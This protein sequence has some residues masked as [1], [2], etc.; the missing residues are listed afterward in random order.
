MSIEHIKFLTLSIGAK[1]VKLTSLLSNCF[2][3]QYL[4]KKELNMPRS[5]SIFVSKS[6]D[7]VTSLPRNTLSGGDKSILVVTTVG[8][9]LGL[10]PGK[11]GWTVILGGL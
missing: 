8:L 4:S 10:D 9:G 11:V 7:M 5:F 3:K 2:F 1:T 6:A